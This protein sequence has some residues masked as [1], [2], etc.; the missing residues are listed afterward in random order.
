[1][2]S[3]VVPVYN[4]ER[5]LR[6]CLNSLLAQTYSDIEIIIVDDGSTDNSFEICQDFQRKDNR[7]KVFH[8]ENSGVSD[9]RN[10]GIKIA[11]GEYISFC[12]SDDVVVPELYQ[13]LLDVV[14]E[15]HVDRVVSGYAYLFDDGRTLYNKP[16][17]ADGKYEARVILKKMIDDGTLSGFLFSGVNNS[18]FKTNI[19]KENEILFDPEIRYNEDSLFSFKYML[20]SKSIFSLQSHPTYF[21]RQHDSSATH[22]KTVGD[23]YGALR[24]TLGNMGLDLMNIDFE[25]QMKRRLVT[26]SLWRILEVSKNEKPSDA[27]LEIQQIVRGKNLRSCL[28]E[29]NESELNIYKKIYFLLIKMKLSRLLY[30]LSSKILPVLSKFLSR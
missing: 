19:I 5:Y 8:K 22:K 11:K 17:I 6:E 26:E 2:I 10:Y 27:I 4:T 28:K 29:I 25:I 3:I 21:Y 13:M 20:Y 15:S 24:M 16:R 23:K 18:I 12:D 30:F 1:M 7:V 14:N 9:S